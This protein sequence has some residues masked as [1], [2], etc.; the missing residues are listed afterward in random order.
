[1]T[2]QPHA[3]RPSSHLGGCAGFWLWALV[4]AAGVLASIS[5]VGLFF[6]VPVAVVAVIVLPRRSGWKNGPALLGV[7]AGA[8]LP[9]LLVAA[10]Q[11]NDWH[12][13]VAGD[14]TPNPFYWGG[15]GLCLLTAGI[16]AYAVRS[17]SSS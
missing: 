17:R 10:L 6:L 7:I 11:W 3:N 1:M 12:D 14:N 8:G 4:G 16:V 9:L 2:V 5:F 13:R 15:A